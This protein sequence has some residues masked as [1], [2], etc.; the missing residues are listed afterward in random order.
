MSTTNLFPT[1]VTSSVV[2]P[3]SGTFIGQG[4]GGTEV[5]NGVIFGVYTG[6][7]DFIT[8]A[9]DQVGYVYKKLG[10]DVLDVE[11]TETQVYSAYEEA[12][13]EYSYIVNLHQAKNSLSDLLGSQTGSF[14][15][16]GEYKAGEISASLGHGP[17]GGN[18][19][20]TKYPNITFAYEKKT[21]QAVSNEANL[22][23]YQTVYSASFNTTGGVQDYDLQSIISEK[24]GTDTGLAYYNKVGNNRLLIRKVFYKTPNAMWRFF[25]YYG[26]LN[27]VGNL[28]NYGQWADDSQFQIVPV[29]QNKQ[30]AMA[31]KD[32]IY[33]RNSQFSFELKNNKLRLFP[34]PQTSSPDK[35]WVEFV[36]ANETEPWEEN[37]NRQNNVG[38]V[39]NMNTLPYKNILYEKINSMGKQWIRR[40][41]LSLC[42]EILGQVRSKFGTIPI[43]GSNLTLNGDAL[44]TQSQTEQQ[45]LREE[46]RTT[47]D[48][49]TYAK[50]AAD[51]AAKVES[52]LK[53]QERIPLPIFQG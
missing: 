19:V 23:G 45:S 7:V 11:I 50:L 26:G 39:N 43:P 25:G 46:L 37:A 28:Q 44:I 48:E 12:V 2:L 18:N 53:V 22:N 38:G 41:A 35:M 27:A 3:A 9:Q 1:S 36:I 40:F 24:A 30:Q 51:D 29:W 21:G 5:K 6:S 42:K 32:A 14:D 8:G 34:E 15:S 31:F 13:L 4:A 49:L 10:G 47:L 17:Y 33:T 52:V 20:G 16:K